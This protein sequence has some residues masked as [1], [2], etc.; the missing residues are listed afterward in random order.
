MMRKRSKVLLT[1]GI[2]CLSAVVTAGSAV[3][4][5]GRGGDSHG[6]HGG[7]AKIATSS[8]VGKNLLKLEV[9]G[10]VTAID[11]ASVTVSA[12]GTLAPWTC[13]IPTGSNTSSI[14]TG[15]RVRLNCRAAD[16]VLTATRLRKRDKGDRVKVSAR[17]AITALTAESITVA[18][19]GSLPAVT[20]AITSRT[21]QFGTHA[22]G[23]Q[24]KLGCKSKNGQLVAKAIAENAAGVVPPGDKP[25]DENEIEVKGAISALSAESITVGSTTCAIGSG[26]STTGFAVGSTVEIKCTGNPLTLVRI[27]AED[28]VK[29]TP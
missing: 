8:K 9:R 24:A 18:P 28:D 21:R 26:V 3:A 6:K 14:A 4:H 25:N 23:E 29:S 7:K 19:G 22:I 16:G 20:C 13:A 1:T 10:T 17:G 11:A 5:K 12:G 2:L 27:K 15:D